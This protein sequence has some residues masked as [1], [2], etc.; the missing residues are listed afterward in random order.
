MHK[1][2][3]DC[4]H[5]VC[6]VRLTV[7][8]QENKAVIDL[9]SICCPVWYSLRVSVVHDTIDLR[10][11]DVFNVDVLPQLVEDILRNIKI[12]SFL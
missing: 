8:N 3:L 10:L 4:I 1:A 2:I 7:R 9:R 6:G 5:G 11:N 12:S